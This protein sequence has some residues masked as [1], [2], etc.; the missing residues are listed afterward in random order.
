MWREKGTPCLYFGNEKYT[1]PTQT[2]S[3]SFKLFRKK[4]NSCNGRKKVKLKKNFAELKKDFF[5]LKSKVKPD[6]WGKR[7][8]TAEQSLKKSETKDKVKKDPKSGYEEKKTSLSKETEKQ[9]SN[10]MQSRSLAQLPH[11]LPI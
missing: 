8:P 10:V 9:N 4:K 2:I 6:D 5:F 7:K 3:Y 1:G 11:L